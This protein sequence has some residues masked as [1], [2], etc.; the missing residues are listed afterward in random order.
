MTSAARRSDSTRTRR[1]RRGYGLQAERARAGVEVEHAA[2]PHA[3]RASSAE[4]SASRTRSLVGRVPARRRAQRRPPATPAMIRVTSAPLQVGGVLGVDPGAHR[5]GQCRVPVEV[6]VV[7]DEGE[8]VLACRGDDVLV[9]EDV[10]E[11]ELGAPAVLRGAEDVAL[12]ALRQVEPGQLEA[13]GRGGDGV[14]PVMG[15]RSARCR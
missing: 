7:G 15:R 11:L 9:L 14:E 13:V 4:N 2:R 5:R 12:A 6:G 1:P 10:E 8:G 3:S